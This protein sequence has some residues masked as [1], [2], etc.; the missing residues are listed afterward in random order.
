MASME[1][2][3]S[4]ARRNYSW[5]AYGA[6]RAAQEVNVAESKSPPMWSII[7]KN[8]TALMLIL[9]AVLFLFGI[10]TL[11]QVAEGSSFAKRI[12]KIKVELTEVQARNELLQGEV[13]ELSSATRIRSLALNKLG[14]VEPAAVVPIGLPKM[15]APGTEQKQW[16]VGI[17]Q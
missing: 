11:T 14:M 1:R 12:G 8:Q 16:V 13:N 7:V 15:P 3:R 4:G 2:N 10:F 6:N 9:C 5:S 17:G